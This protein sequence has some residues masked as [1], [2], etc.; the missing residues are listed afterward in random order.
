MSLAGFEI[1]PAKSEETMHE[2]NCC[3][4]IWR[5]KSKNDDNNKDYRSREKN[6]KFHFLLL[7]LMFELFDKK[8]ALI[9]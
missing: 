2:R 9:I 6:Y 4:T 8:L 1:R 7:F 3:F 5:R